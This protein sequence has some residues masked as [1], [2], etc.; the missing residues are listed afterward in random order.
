MSFTGFHHEVSWS[1]C[2]FHWVGVC[3]LSR[4]VKGSRSQASK[5]SSSPQEVLVNI[6]E[7]W[8]KKQWLS[9]PTLKT[10]RFLLEGN[11]VEASRP[12]YGQLVIPAEWLT[13]AWAKATQH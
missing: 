8:P 13:G 4:E 9:S 11:H 10:V 2:S 5:N 3:T 1:E 12:F 6:T 7:K